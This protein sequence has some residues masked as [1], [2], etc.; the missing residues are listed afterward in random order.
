MG[1]AASVNVEALA[2]EG[3]KPADASDIGDTLEAAQAEVSRLRTLMSDEMGAMKE[4][5]ANVAA[6][7][8]HHNLGVDH[9]TAENIWDTYTRGKVLGE[10]VTGKVYELVN[11]ET[12]DRFALKTIDKHLVQASMLHTLQEEIEMLKELNSPHIIKLYE[13]FHEPGAIH[14]VQELAGGGELF[15]H[16]ENQP[17]GHYT[18]HRAAIVIRTMLSAIAHCHEL[19]IVHRDL[20]LENFVFES[21]HSEANMKLIDFGLSK[22]F[23]V[24][25]LRARGQSKSGNRD[26][27]TGMHSCVGT[28]Y[29]IAPEILIE[30]TGET[31]AGY[32]SAVDCWSIGVIAY[33]LLTSVPPF[34]SEVDA[35]IYRQ[36]LDCENALEFPPD[37]GFG[38]TID[39]GAEDLIRSLLTKDPNSRATATQ[40]LQHPWITKHWK[41]EVAALHAEHGD[42]IDSPVLDKALLGSM[43]GFRKSNVFR[44]L[45]LEV[46]AYNLT[47]QEI[48]GLQEKFEEIDTAGTG[49]ISLPELVEAVRASMPEGEFEVG[50]ENRASIEAMF[51]SLDTTHTG[52]VSYLEFIAGACGVVCSL[53]LLPPSNE[54]PVVMQLTLLPPPPPVSATMRK[55]TWD[56]EQRLHQAFNRM[57][58]H[59]EGFITKEDLVELVGSEYSPEEMDEMIANVDEDGNG[60]I[61]FHEFCDCMHEIT[62]KFHAQGDGTSPRASSS[63]P[64]VSSSSPRATAGAAPSVAD[65]A[66]SVSSA[67]ETAAAPAAT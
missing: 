29:Y 18:V 25:R 63:S 20:K 49:I 38:T 66:A 4:H 3:A 59:H 52:T 50:S 65:D 33:M 23:S 62:N 26:V 31:A 53:P 58:L 1:A 47:G 8:L 42:P 48:K 32:T 44:K 34:D 19:G 64:R 27:E 67:A 60:K 15:D 9:T 36:I 51:D 30:S 16:L 41:N 57:D 54:L 11:K 45:A 22:K 40:A 56:T 46:I 7:D 14:M 5:A 21:D 37:L 35:E 17:E 12:G 6:H 55:R 39:S 13:T 61:D 24:A 2:L 28:I 10:G 43:Q